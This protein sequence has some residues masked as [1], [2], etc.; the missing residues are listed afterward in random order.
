M[1]LCLSRLE[2]TPQLLYDIVIVFVV[3][4]WMVRL[5]LKHGDLLLRKILILEGYWDVICFTF[6]PN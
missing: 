2:G 4:S 5:I 6:P 3:M 1:C